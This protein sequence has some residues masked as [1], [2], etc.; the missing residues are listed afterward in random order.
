MN[1]TNSFSPQNRNYLNMKTG[2]IP[3][4]SFLKSCTYIIIS[5]VQRNSSAEDKD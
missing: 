1:N 5:S 4:G 3:E 2:C